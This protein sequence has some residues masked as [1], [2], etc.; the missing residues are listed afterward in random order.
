MTVRNK[1]A[2]HRAANRLLWALALL[3]AATP[4]FSGCANFGSPP[5]TLS[6]FEPYRVRGRTYVPL[7]KWESYQEIGVASWYG[8]RFHG[9]TT[10]NGERFDSKSS[11]TAAHRTL[12]FNVCAAVKHLPTGRSVTVRINDRGPFA[13]GRVIDL[14]RA[15]MKELG[16]LEEGLVRVRVSAVGIAGADGRCRSV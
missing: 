7:R 3:L 4:L 10:A 8:G 15:A 2:P 12:P 6:G 1:R 14:S 11:L 16:V 9:R 5:A 13:R